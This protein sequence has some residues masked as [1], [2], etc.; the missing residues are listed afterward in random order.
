MFIKSHTFNELK[1]EKQD[2]VINSYMDDLLCEIFY[3]ASIFK[4][5]ND[6][7]E[8]LNLLLKQSDNEY[9]FIFKLKDDNV[10]YCYFRNICIEDLKDC[11]FVKKMQSH[12]VGETMKPVILI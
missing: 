3:L 1:K 11:F 12:P 10:L 6:I 7:A 9:D 4:Y 8:K 2:E 5:P